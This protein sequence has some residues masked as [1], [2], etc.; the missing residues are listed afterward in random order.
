MLGPIVVYQSRGKLAALLL[1]SLL[2]VVL[3]A[4]LL[5]RYP[6]AL[7]A[8]TTIAAA[9]GIPFF[10]VCGLFALSRLLWRKPAIIVNDE[11]LTDKASAASVG[12]IPW[13]D[14]A[15]ARIVVQTFGGSRQKYLGVLLRN[16]NDYLAKS[17][18][19]TRGLL[20]ASAGMTG[21]VVNIPQV[22]LSVGL[23]AVLAHIEFFL[24][25]RGDG[26]CESGSIG[27]RSS[28]MESVDR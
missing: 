5:S 22:A 25:Q 27:A 13:S 19:L 12:F 2:L 17:R 11:G 20:R 16:P 14:I 6:A 9:V 7:N 3:C 10:S 21:C 18:P 28:S 8:K 4:L 23:E 1:G 26:H 15:S 24:Q